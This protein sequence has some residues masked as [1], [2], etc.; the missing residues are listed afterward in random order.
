MR[1]WVS[2]A[3]ARLC[4]AAGRRTTMS[5]SPLD[6]LPDGGVDL[7]NRQSL[8]VDLLHP[9]VTFQ[10]ATAPAPASRAAYDGARTACSAASSFATARASEF[11]PTIKGFRQNGSLAKPNASA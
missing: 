11:S 1:T 7:A 5:R 2:T 6:Q 9:A 10:T 8:A 4:R 3:T